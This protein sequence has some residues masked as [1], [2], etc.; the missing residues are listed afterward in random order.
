MFGSKTLKMKSPLFGRGF[1][2]D[3]SVSYFEQIL[4]DLG[5]EVKSSSV[6]KSPY[7]DGGVVIY[8]CETKISKPIRISVK[9]HAEELEKEFKSNIKWGE[10][11]TS[12][13]KGGLTD[14]KLIE[15]VIGKVLVNR[16]TGEYFDKIS[17]IS[18]GS[19]TLSEGGY[20]SSW[21]WGDY[22]VL[23]SITRK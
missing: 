1:V 12:Y 9:E 3:D 13:Q 19:V 20:M 4:K 11:L 21:G 22:R 7:T 15:D 10:P 14:L 2:V 8:R 18:A 5:I 16:K 6:V 17:G 23:Q